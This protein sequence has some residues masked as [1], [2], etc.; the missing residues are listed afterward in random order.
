MRT[1]ALATLIA[2][3]TACGGDDFRDV[4]KAD[5]I[6]AYEAYLA[7]NSPD[8]NTL[9]QANTRL[10]ELYLDKAKATASLEAYDVYLEKYP[11]G[12]LRERG[13]K[14]R[15]QFLFDWALSERSVE[16]WSTFLE[17]Y[18]K[19]EKDRKRKAKKGLAIA[20]YSPS[21]E[22]GAVQ[23]SETNLAEDPEGAMD[24]YKWT[25]DVTNKGDQQLQHLALTIEYVDAAGATVK[26][27]EWPV[28]SDSWKIPMPD[29][30]YVP[31]KPGDTRTWEW[32]ESK[33]V[34]PEGADPSKAKVY[35]TA[36]SFVE[37]E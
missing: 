12:R 35:P 9:L 31:M 21:L 17:Q 30:A 23:A 4:Q 13:L 36:V 18:P 1:I 15:E 14:E 28:V 24:G 8:R 27:K 3:F 26:V 10:E 33:E 37:A 20:E 22:Q 25:V 19:A 5:S 16:A 6:E 34:Y 7:N 32:T 2:L 11:E 29:E